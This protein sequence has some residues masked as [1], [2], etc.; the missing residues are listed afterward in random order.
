MVA[1][2]AENDGDGTE[3]HGEITEL[4]KQVHELRYMALHLLREY[5]KV[6]QE[7][8]MLAHRTVGDD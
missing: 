6:K 8:D 4:R 1:R 5:R 7:R 2:K 3:H